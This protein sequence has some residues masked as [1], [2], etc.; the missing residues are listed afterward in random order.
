MRTS[1]PRF[2]SRRRRTFSRC[3]WQSEF[4]AGCL[5]WLYCCPQ[6]D[7]PRGR[8][9]RGDPQRG[10]EGNT[11]NY[12]DASRCESRISKQ[13]ST[14]LAESSPDSGAVC[15]SN[16]L[17]RNQVE[18]LKDPDIE[19][20]SLDGTSCKANVSFGRLPADFLFIVCQ[21]SLTGHSGGA[22]RMSM[23]RNWQA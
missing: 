5:G 13:K 1:S 15:H 4:N 16:F 21:K 2:S 12:F 23:S 20:A 22:P 6:I 3:S 17:G 14:Y 8:F 18:L 19:V 7:G 10:S 9:Q 11:G